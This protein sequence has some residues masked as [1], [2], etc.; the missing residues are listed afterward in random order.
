MQRPELFLVEVK[1]SDSVADVFARPS[2]VALCADSCA[3][4]GPAKQV[5][6]Q[7]RGWARRVYEASTGFKS[8]GGYE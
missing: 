1:L 6:S 4:A 2:G 3:R 7:G 5:S 8:L